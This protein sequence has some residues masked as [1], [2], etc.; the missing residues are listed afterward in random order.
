MSKHDDIMR[1]QESQLFT[2]RRLDELNEA[3]LDIA[4]RLQRAVDQLAQLEARMDAVSDA[5]SETSTDDLDDESPA[6]LS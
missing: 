3:I 4:T 2:D 1:L 6:D 5:A